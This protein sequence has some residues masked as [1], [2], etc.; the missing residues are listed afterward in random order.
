MF[1]L[2]PNSYVHRCEWMWEGKS[3]L[4]SACDF[5][6]R[7]PYPS[8]II[9]MCACVFKFSLKLHDKSPPLAEG[10]S[11]ILPRHNQITLKCKLSH[12]KTAV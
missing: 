5:P 2:C 3:L 11:H 8:L 12:F 4:N 9:V 7:N 1:K 10:L 6:I